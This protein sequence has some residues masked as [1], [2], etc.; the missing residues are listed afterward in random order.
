MV[1]GAK[2]GGDGSNNDWWA[3]VRALDQISKGNNIVVLQL[4]CSVKINNVL[5]KNLNS[6]WLTENII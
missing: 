3:K 4:S 6:I 5:E 2:P 1:G